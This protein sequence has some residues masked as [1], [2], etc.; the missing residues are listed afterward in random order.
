MVYLSQHTY[1]LFVM[2]D[3]VVEK[4]R[5]NEHTYCVALSKIAC[6]RYLP[7]RINETNNR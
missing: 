2:E 4:I 3:N 7:F 6:F 5:V 1:I